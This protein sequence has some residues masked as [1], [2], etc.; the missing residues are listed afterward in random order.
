MRHM[1]HT[2]HMV[3][4]SKSY[5]FATT[6]RGWKPD[7]QGADPVTP[8]SAQT[9]AGIQ[10]CLHCALEA[11]LD[12]LASTNPAHQAERYTPGVELVAST[13][14]QQAETVVGRIRRTP[15]VIRQSI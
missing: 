1:R 12:R 6:S 4:A 10:K 2:R 15:C 8:Y 7:P 3:V 14:R 13:L 9:I 11:E 5:I